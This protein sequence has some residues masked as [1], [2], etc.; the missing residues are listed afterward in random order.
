M[1][2]SNAPSIPRQEPS[3]ATDF[4]FAQVDH[5]LTRIEGMLERIERQAWSIAYLGMAILAIEGLRVL[6]AV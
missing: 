4:W 3:P 6:I 2:K 5:R 1:T